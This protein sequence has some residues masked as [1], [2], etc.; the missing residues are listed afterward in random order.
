MIRF[1]VVIILIFSLF[2]QVDDKAE[3]SARIR[4]LLSA[5]QVEEALTFADDCLNKSSD[6]EFYLGWKLELLKISKQLDRAIECALTLEEVSGGKKVPSAYNLAELY[7]ENGNLAKTL[8]W[9][10]QAAQRGLKDPRF[11]GEEKWD[12]MKKDPHYE[13]ILRRVQDNQGI[14]QP[15]PNFS[16]TLLGGDDFSLFQMRGKVVLIDFWATWCVPCVATIPMLKEYYRKYSPQGFEIIAVSLD[17]DIEKLK[18]YLNE[19]PIPWM[20]SFSGQEWGQDK[21][22]NLYGVEMIPTTFLVDKK[23]HPAP[24]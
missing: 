9:M 1:A 22:A 23:R 13:A 17:R 14:G 6:K 10:E 20:I 2:L 4:E 12:A 16:V 24:L 7:L 15:V 3:N 19:E 21:T 5:G 8:H 18:E 11:F